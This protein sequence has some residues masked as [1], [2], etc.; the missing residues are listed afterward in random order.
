MASMA[1]ISVGCDTIVAQVANPIFEK[2]QFYVIISSAIEPKL[3]RPPIKIAERS[4]D[5]KITVDVFVNQK[6]H[7]PTGHLNFI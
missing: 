1:I 7:K 4:H 2:L 5:F 3:Q 6:V